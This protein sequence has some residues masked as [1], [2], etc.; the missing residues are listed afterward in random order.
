MAAG[1]GEERLVGAVDEEPSALSG[2][3]NGF[4]EPFVAMREQSV[5]LPVRRSCATG[6]LSILGGA[7]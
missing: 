7:T 3:G 5:R 6:N 2:F 4:V 1:I